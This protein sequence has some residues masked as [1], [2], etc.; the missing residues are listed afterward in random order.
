MP[1]RITGA[2]FDEVSTVDVPANQHGLIV[3]AKRANAEETTVPQYFDA[4]GAPV[5]IDQLPEG[6]LVQDEHGAVLEVT[7]EDDD[8]Y[9]GAAERELELVGKSAFLANVDQ[10]SDSLFATLHKSLQEAVADDGARAQIAKAFADQAAELSK[11]QHTASQAMELAKGLQEQ[12]EVAAYISKAAEWEGVGVAADV[13]GPVLHRMAKSMS[14]EDCT[15]IRQVLDNSGDIF[16]S[17][18]VDGDHVLD[19]P[20]AEIQAYANEHSAELAKSAG[21]DVLSKEQAT[22][23]FFDTNSDAR[24]AYTLAKRATR[25]RG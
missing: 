7:F 23:A 14:N 13:L 22:A 25:A 17:Y 10:A 15:V 9:D 11:A 12:T 5:D 6:T 8:A 20:L 1:N 18:G 16:K 21:R 24:R 4:D 3:L 19:D 2:D